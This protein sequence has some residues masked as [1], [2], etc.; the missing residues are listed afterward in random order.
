M[1]L[2][3]PVTVIGDDVPD[4]FM[5]PGDEI[6]VYPKIVDPPLFVGAT[7]DTSD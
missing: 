7:K 6:T 4:F 2:V 1:S 3:N 5:L